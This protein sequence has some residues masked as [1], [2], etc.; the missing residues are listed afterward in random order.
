[1]KNGTRAATKKQPVSEQNSSEIAPQE[2]KKEKLKED[3]VELPLLPVRNTVL[4]PNLVIPLLVGRDQSMK[5]LEDA[6]SKNRTVFV[7]TQRNED[8]EDPGAE[9]VYHIGVE[10]IIE[11]LLKLPD[12]TTS[13]LIRGERRLRRIEYTQQLPFMRVR[14]EP[15]QEVIEETLALE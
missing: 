14:V 3:I 5:A 10:G 8:M 2:E 9:D 11:R 7:V 1:M 6:M 13:V 15:L 12:G 4:V